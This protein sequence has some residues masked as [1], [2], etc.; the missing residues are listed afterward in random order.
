MEICSTDGEGPPFQRDSSCDGRGAE[1]LCT[2]YFYNQDLTVG[3]TIKLSASV[4][5]NIALVISVPE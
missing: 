3:F 4:L 5:V 1:V 2:N